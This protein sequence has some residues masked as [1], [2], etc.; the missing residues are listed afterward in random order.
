MVREFLVRDFLVR[1]FSGEEF[2]GE[3]FSGERFLVWDCRTRILFCQNSGNP[4]NPLPHS[5]TRPCTYDQIFWQFVYVHGC[6]F[7]KIFLAS[8]KFWYT[9]ISALAPTLVKFSH[10]KEV[11]IA[12]TVG[13]LVTLWRRKPLWVLSSKVQGSNGYPLIGELYKFI[14]INFEGNEVK[15]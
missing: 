6:F 14:G 13:F 10:L 12:I 3:G 2:S 9:R 8:Q 11:L 5:H 4:K 15:S 7:N 1:D